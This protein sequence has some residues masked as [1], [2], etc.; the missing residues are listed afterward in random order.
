MVMTKDSRLGESQETRRD[1]K[2]APGERHPLFGALKHT[3]FVPPGVDLT[4]PTDPDW[5]MSMKM[6]ALME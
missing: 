6:V 4:E 5:A 3:T 1:E 2:I